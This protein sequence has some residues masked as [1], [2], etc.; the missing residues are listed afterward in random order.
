MPSHFWGVRAER[1]ECYFVGATVRLFTLADFETSAV[2]VNLSPPSLLIITEDFNVSS[3]G[4]VYDERTHFIRR[5][6]FHRICSQSR[7]EREKNRE[8]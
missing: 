7:R 2:K 8:K 3:T 4:F 5:N 6:E 1:S